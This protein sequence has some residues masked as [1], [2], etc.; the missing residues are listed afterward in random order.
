MAKQLGIWARGAAASAVLG[1]AGVGGVGGC[2]NTEFIN[3]GI[4][5]DDMPTEMAAAICKWVEG[6]YTG[7]GLALRDQCLARAT[8]NVVDGKGPA[9]GAG[10][11][12]KRIEY[13]A[14]QA[15]ACLDALAA[16]GRDQ[17]PPPACFATFK[18]QVALGGECLN[19]YDC[20][21][22]AYC[23]AGDTCPGICTAWGGAGDACTTNDGCDRNFR[24]ISNVCT[25]TVGD[26]APCT[27]NADCNYDLLCLSVEGDGKCVDV[28]DYLTAKEGEACGTFAP[29][30]PQAP[31]CELEFVC[32]Q[33]STG[34]TTATCKKRVGAGDECSLAFLSQCPQ[35]YECPETPG[36]CELLPT[37][38]KCGELYGEALCQPGYACI[39]DECTKQV[40]N[41]ATCSSN[42]ECE[43]GRCLDGTCGPQFVCAPTE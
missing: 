39:S 14:T 34:S 21:G 27:T 29:D 20:A 17:Q 12:D 26:N 33:D 15:S 23:E 40:S 32:A 37:S 8:P 28:G 43:S 10:I 6:C 41:G 19:S 30:L 18:G 1:I 22:D 13:Y 11:E 4:P 42:G 16:C 3:E 9:I 36:V 31:L 35:A 7:G 2:T 24:C 25:A 5:F 38:G